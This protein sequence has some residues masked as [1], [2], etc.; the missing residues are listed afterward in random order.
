MLDLRKRIVLI[1]SLIVALVIVVILGVL[2]FDRTQEGDPDTGDI[3]TTPDRPDAADII[4][5]PVAGNPTQLSESLLLEGGDERYV[6]QLAIDFV[7]RFGSYSSE[8]RN[9]HIDDVLPLVTDTMAQWIVTQEQSYSP[10]YHGASTKVIVS[11]TEHYEDTRATVYI[12]AQQTQ[13][14]QDTSER[15]YNTGRVELV[16]VG[17]EWKVSGLFWN[18]IR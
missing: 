16:K 5:S 11:R 7:E 15:L 17:E 13:E 3:S 2:L 1:I 4:L 14:G 10:E 12:E 6:R 18:N 9:D 8:E